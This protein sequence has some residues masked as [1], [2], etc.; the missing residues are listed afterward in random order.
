MEKESTFGTSS[1]AGVVGYEKT[2][3][4][5]R[6]LRISSGLTLREVEER[7]NGRWKAVVIG[8]YERGTRHL[9][10]LKALEL[11]QF[12]GSDLTALGELIPTEN[13]NRLIIDL[14][15]LAELRTL[16]DHLSKQ[17]ARFLNQLIQK[18][19]DRNSEVLSIR[20]SDLETIQLLVGGTKEEILTALARRK[21]ILR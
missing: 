9:S 15:K 21:L 17:L 8:S 13:S 3:A 11:C 16:P 1:G 5:L 14:R 6:N 20:S 10:L 18:R 7:S 19:G 2:L 4:R 12:Y